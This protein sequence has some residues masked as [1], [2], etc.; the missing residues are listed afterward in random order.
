MGGLQ[1][2]VDLA[3]ATRPVKLLLTLPYAHDMCRSAMMPPI[4]AI[5]CEM[6]PGITT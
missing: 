3:T 4:W 5:H 2:C 6:I 1:V